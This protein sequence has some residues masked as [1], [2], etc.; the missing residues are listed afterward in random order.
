MNK[1]YIAEDSLGNLYNA[2]FKPDYVK[3]GEKYHGYCNNNR[4][5]LFY[6]FAVLG[7]DLQFDYKDTT[8][9]FLS[10]QDYVARCDASYKKDLEV[11]ENANTMIKSFRMDGIPL[12]DLIDEL[13]NVDIH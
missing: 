3:N 2:E 12:I 9:F 8:F 6:Y 4:E 1:S 10:E 11:F 5:A 13:K 7:Y